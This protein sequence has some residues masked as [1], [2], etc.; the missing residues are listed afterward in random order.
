MAPVQVELIPKK[1]RTLNAEK[2]CKLAFWMRDHPVDCANGT[3]VEIAASA[4]SALGFAVGENTIQE[5]RVAIFPEL[6]RQP[7]KQ[8]L[9]HSVAELCERVGKIEAMLNRIVPG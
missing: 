8:D 7:K 2:R 5:F 6:K 4:S 1:S 3:A 9:E